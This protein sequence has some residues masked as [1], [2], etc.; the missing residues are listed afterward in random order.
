MFK[1]TMLLCTFVMTMFYVTKAFGI[2]PPEFLYPADAP[3]LCGPYDQVET[4]LGESG[5]QPVSVGFGRAGGV[6]DGQQVFAILGYKHEDNGTM[7]ATVE[8]PSGMDKCI[9]YTIFD[10]TEVGQIDVKN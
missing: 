1:R 7:I 2:N 5:Y 6:P 3:I 9:I 8:T 4:F 10:F